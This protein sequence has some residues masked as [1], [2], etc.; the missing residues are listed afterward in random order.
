MMIEPPKRERKATYSVDKYYRDIL[1]P[2]AATTKKSNAPKAP[3]QTVMYPFIYLFSEIG[4]LTHCIDMI[5][6]SSLRNC[7]NS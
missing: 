5:S 6:N 1:T 2:G 7:S 3:K 4:Y